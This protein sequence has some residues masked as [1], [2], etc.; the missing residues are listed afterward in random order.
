M[1]DS[2]TRGEVIVILVN[3]EHYGRAGAHPR[4]LE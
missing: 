4:V 2:L 1:V 3:A